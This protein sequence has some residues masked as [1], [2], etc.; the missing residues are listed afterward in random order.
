ML[1]AS[2][3]LSEKDLNSKIV[4]IGE[5]SW[6]F[7]ERFKNANLILVLTKDNYSNKEESKSVYYRRTLEQIETVKKSSI[8]K[9]F[10]PLYKKSTKSLFEV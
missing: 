3:L 1:D 7:I 4:R 9:M 5:S 10:Q 6:Y 8:K 2:L